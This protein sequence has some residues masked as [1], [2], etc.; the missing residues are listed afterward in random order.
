MSSLFQDKIFPL[1]TVEFLAFWFKITKKGRP[2]NVFVV[3]VV[4]VAG[5]FFCWGGKG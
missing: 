5:L 1:R 4:V 3:V 2:L